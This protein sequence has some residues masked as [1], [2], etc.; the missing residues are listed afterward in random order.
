MDGLGAWFGHEFVDEA[1]VG[2]GAS[3][4]D[5]IVPAS[6]SVGIEVARF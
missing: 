6:R 3:S 1:D 2:E 5:V 4:H